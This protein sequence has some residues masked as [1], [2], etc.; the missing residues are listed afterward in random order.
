M[1]LRHI[2][3]C[4]LLI[5]QMYRLW[6][7]IEDTHVVKE[8]MH[9]NL[10]KL[11]RLWQIHEGAEYA[12]RELDVLPLSCARRL[13]LARMYTIE[14]WIEPAVHTMLV[15]RDFRL[16]SDEEVDQMGL[17][18]FHILTKGREWLHR[19]KRL[20]AITP[21][22]MAIKPSRECE[23]HSTCRVHWKKAWKDSVAAAL[24]HP[25]HPIRLDNLPTFVEKTEIPGVSINCKAEVVRDMRAVG[26]AD[27]R[28]VEG[29]VEKI[30]EYYRSL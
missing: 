19:E 26:F 30:K 12:I 13:Q 23:D 27:Q 5:Y 29:A 10:L 28:I 24:L 8:R 4:D 7:P 14:E 18:V 1:H 2:Y 16:V 20:V 15:Y 22:P 6:R 3:C 21:W 11:S 25:D 9:V 17:R